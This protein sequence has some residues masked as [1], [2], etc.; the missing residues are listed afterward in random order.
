MCQTTLAEQHMERICGLESALRQRE[1]SLQKLS[2][3]LRS[4]DVH[5]SHLHASLDVPRGGFNKETKIFFIHENN[6]NMISNGRQLQ[7]V[8]LQNEMFAKSL[9]KPC[10]LE[11]VSTCSSLQPACTDRF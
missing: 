7:K 6:I 2:A 3:Q 4:K 11:S 9:D 10:P 8:G 5:Q 1:S